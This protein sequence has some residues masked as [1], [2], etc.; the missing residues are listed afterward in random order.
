MQTSLAN[1][2]LG[3]L[4]QLGR[5]RGELS[6]ADLQKHLP[7]Q[8]MSSDEIARVV[9][10]LENEG[11]E[12][13]LTSE[14]LV[15]RPGRLTQLNGEGVGSAE[16]MW[17]EKR[18]GQPSDHVIEPVRTPEAREPSSGGFETLSV[19][20]AGLIVCAVALVIVWTLV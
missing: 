7:I 2:S 15:P 19:V 1:D 5:L 20:L 18:I 6:A 9:T 13:T 16:A 12:I 4:A 10:Y 8:A 3:L 11:I 14:L 17:P